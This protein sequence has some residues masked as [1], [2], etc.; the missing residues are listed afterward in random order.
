MKPQYLV[1][2]VQTQCLPRKGRRQFLSDHTA[3]LLRWPRTP[4]TACLFPLKQQGSPFQSHLS[5]D[6]V[7]CAYNGMSAQPNIGSQNSRA[8]GTPVSWVKDAA[9]SLCYRHH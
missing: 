3:R 4:V 9:S 6:F 2:I 7:A 5:L 1:A 8:R